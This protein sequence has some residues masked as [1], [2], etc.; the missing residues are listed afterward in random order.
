MR[1][2]QRI[3]SPGQFKHGT[4]RGFLEG[5]RMRVFEKKGELFFGLMVCIFIGI[6]SNA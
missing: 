4:F 6:S 1:I 5:W 2:R 3:L